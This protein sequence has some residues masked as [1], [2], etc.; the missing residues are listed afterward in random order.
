[1][2]GLEHSKVSEPSVS[3]FFSDSQSTVP[4]PP[5]CT[6]F[7]LVYMF[8]TPDGKIDSWTRDLDVLFTFGF[9][10]VVMW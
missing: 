6:S 7:G 9:Y 4:N 1:M 10:R 8:G 5:S 2:V 3:S